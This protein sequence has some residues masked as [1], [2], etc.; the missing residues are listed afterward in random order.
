MGFI[1]YLLPDKSKKFDHALHCVVFFAIGFLNLM[2][3]NA[4]PDSKLVA[5]I[6]GTALGTTWTAA[7]YHLGLGIQAFRI[8]T[9]GELQTGEALRNLLTTL[10]IVLVTANMGVISSSDVSFGL[11]FDGTK[12]EK[13]MAYSALS[14]FGL[15]LARFLDMLLDHDEAKGV[16]SIDEVKVAGF[17]KEEKQDA[18]P[19]WGTSA[20]NGRIVITH[21]FLLSTVVTSMMLWVGGDYRL[22]NT[23]S[24]DDLLMTLGAIFTLVH[25]A[26]Y[27]LAL[28]LGMWDPVKEGVVACMTCC[29]NIKKEKENPDDLTIESWNRVPLL[30]WLVTTTVIFCFAFL[31]GHTFDNERSQLVLINL[32]FYLAADQVG[33]H[34]V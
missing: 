10:S 33:R 2:A 15:L 28:L 1:H 18:E 11:K 5:G 23:T 13:V 24:G 17:G 20:L 19:M 12:D 31:A 34:V 16:L 3:I 21:L 25:F 9:S 14:L 7:I 30:R 6:A 27:P 29:K 22:D 26:L 32:V 8:P 4:H